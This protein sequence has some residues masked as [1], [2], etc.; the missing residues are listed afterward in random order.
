MTDLR[1]PFIAL[2]ARLLSMA[3]GL[4]QRA[5]IEAD[6]REEFRHHL[7]LETERLMGRGLSRREATRQA[8]LNFGPIES[9][10]ESA[11]E[12]RGLHMWDEFRFSWLDLKLGLRMLLKY[13]GLTAVAILALGV[14]IPIGLTPLH[15]A[16]AVEAP[17]PE[18]RGNRIQAIRYWDKESYSLEETT[19]YEYQRFRD[20]LESF[21]LFGA[22]A[23]D[24]FNVGFGTSSGELIESF[25]VNGVRMSATTF[26]LLG[27]VPLLGR[28]LLAS[29]QRPGAPRVAVL[30][31]DLWRARFGADPNVVGR[32][33]DVGGVDHTIVGVMPS[34]F[35]FPSRHQ[36]W[37]PLTEESVGQP[38][39]GTPI[40]LYARLA[41]GVTRAQ[42][43][44]E[45]SAVGERLRAQF[46]ESHQHL[47]PEAV[48]F[49]F[50]FMS[51]PRGGLDNEPGFY[52]FVVLG[53]GLLLV[54]CVNVGLL[55]FARTATRFRELAVRT[56]LGASR[57]RVL[58]QM[59]A[60]SL[61]MALAAAGLGSAVAHLGLTS[62]YS[63]AVRLGFP[64]PYWLDLGVT[65]R[66]LAMALGLAALCAVVAGVVPGLRLTRASLSSG[67][68][69][70]AGRSGLRF[71]SATGVLIVLDVA[72]ATAAI[73]LALG[74]SQHLLDAQNTRARTGVEPSE[75]LSAEIRLPNKHS[76]SPV[77][78]ETDHQRRLAHLH[79]ELSERLQVEPEVRGVALANALPR[80]DHQTRKI[81]L[82]GDT[83]LDIEERRS[84]RIAKVDVDF[85]EGLGQSI[86]AGRGFDRSDLQPQTRSVI[87]NHDFAETHFAGQD[88]VGQRLGI[89]KRGQIASDDSLQG[90]A[91]EGVVRADDW[92]EV[93]GVVGALGMNVVSSDRGQGMYFPVAPG[94]LHPIRVGLHLNGV[95]QE[96]TP[97]LREIL[98]NIEPGAVLAN[99]RPLDEVY[100]GDWYLLIATALGLVLLVGIL[101]AL[102]TCG[103]FAM[104]S[105]S[106]TE[107]TAEI[108]IRTALGAARSAIVTM[109]LRRSV[110][111]LGLGALIGTPLA[112]LAMRENTSHWFAGG[113]LALGLGLAVMA[114]IGILAC[115]TPTLRALE[116]E[117]RGALKEAE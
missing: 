16:R 96:F 51:L 81:A 8:R 41:T 91:I 93:V 117:P 27:T 84:V 50:L 30:N 44:A 69:G 78:A 19:T 11:R 31:Q 66:S 10:K 21:D 32:S 73:G 33:I 37:L 64:L 79:R 97:R 14:G 5:Q 82:Q 114:T 74:F 75:Y 57:M 76:F 52:A 99:P 56:A 15:L 70:R 68:K 9:T 62:V 45:L 49:A 102:A 43:Q 88:P 116:I 111:Q 22:A 113:A 47:H 86:L 98:S 106:V 26:D 25:P 46:A 53:L 89:V 95:P 94:Q 63:W 39:Q 38:G 48:P 105:F 2:S 34:G 65:P 58:A 59:F 12:A 109:V 110:F 3:R 40:L 55:I 1:R 7:E 35:L 4:H 24:T 87:V 17:L 83:P 77:E 72:V 6:M 115:T 18:D 23:T 80:M 100:Q 90:L 60:E 85:F 103:I 107:R 36:L 92:Y 54:A 28:T 67:L 29:D 42:A 13:P 61:V 112:F 71:G 104:V 101:L 20:E 108:G